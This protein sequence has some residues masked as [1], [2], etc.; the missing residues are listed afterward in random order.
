MAKRP[1]RLLPLT[2]TF[3]IA[4]DHT[5]GHRLSAMFCY[6]QH[7]VCIYL[8]CDENNIIVSKCLWYWSLP[9]F[10]M[11]FMDKIRVN[12]AWVLRP[13]RKSHFHMRRHLFQKQML[14][15]VM[16]FVNIFKSAVVA[17]YLSASMCV[18][19]RHDIIHWNLRTGF[20]QVINKR[21]M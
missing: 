20:H 5:A 11:R 8:M 6:S 9:N 1:C 2:W 13:L 14:K 3:L 7:G 15:L 16:Y 21:N 12:D 18:T 4:R 19:S 10:V 17:L